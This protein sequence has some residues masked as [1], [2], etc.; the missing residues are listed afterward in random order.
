MGTSNAYLISDNDTVLLVD[1]GN[2]GRIGDMEVALKKNGLEFSDIAIIIVTHSHYDHVG[3]LAE[4]KKRSRAKVIVHRDEANFLS[5]GC[6]P[7]PEGTMICSKVINRIGGLFLSDRARC[8][9]VHPDIIVDGECELMIPGLEVTI[10]PTPGHTSGSVS[11]IIN[12]ECSFVGDTLFSVIPGTVYPPFAN[13]RETLIKSWEK[14]LSI[15][16]RTFYPGHGR[17]FS[18]ETLEKC[19]EKKRT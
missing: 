5:N 3:C 15:G 11:V 12:N 14:L 9:P 16:C 7:F 10:L 13:D 18:R 17:P 8:A 4:I 1:A 6:T 19:F 2:E